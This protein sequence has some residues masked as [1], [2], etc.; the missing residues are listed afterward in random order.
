VSGWI[1][2]SLRP[3]WIH[4]RAPTQFVIFIYPDCASHINSA[5]GI[6]LLPV[7]NIC[8]RWPPSNFNP[9]RIKNI[10][11]CQ[12]YPCLSPSQRPPSN[13][14]PIHFMRLPGAYDF[15][16]QGFV[17]NG[18]DNQRTDSAAS[19]TYD[20]TMPNLE[21]VTKS[22]DGHEEF[23]KTAQSTTTGN[24]DGVAGLT[25]QM[26]G[27]NTR[28]DNCSQYTTRIPLS[29]FS[30]ESRSGLF[31]NV[32][33]RDIY[34]DEPVPGCPVPGHLFEKLQVVTNGRETGIFVSWYVYQTLWIRSDDGTNILGI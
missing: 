25:D 1:H 8:G 32:D 34:E 33:L 29:T 28:Y 27:L 14:L 15:G 4:S 10:P 24:N 19:S 5:E 22:E 7:P 6:L 30:S 17:P 23:L 12:D 3:T 20:L 16:P 21:P 11:I 2:L 18:S 31:P 26:S 13:S 9:L